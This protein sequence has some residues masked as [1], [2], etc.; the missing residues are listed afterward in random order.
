[1]ALGSKALI[2][3]CLTAAAYA[4]EYPARHDHWRRSCT[5]TLKVDD[6]GVSFTS[7]K[8]SFA[9]K[10]EDIQQLDISPKHLRVRTYKDN[11][12]KAGIDETNEFLGSFESA[13][14]LLKGRVL[15]R[16]PDPSVD[17]TWTV[18]VKLMARIRGSEGDLLIGTKQIV[19]RTK[20][21][22]NS[23]T[24]EFD[25]IENIST[26]HRYELTLTTLDRDYCFQ[27]K[28]P[29][30][31]D[32]YDALWLRLQQHKGLKLIGESK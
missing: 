19:Y 4:A 31:Q 30:A 15:N 28:Q 3:L 1:M 7:P 21:P 8:H 5:G 14:P 20:S 17:T 6:A 22:E 2:A 10:Y 32:R 23:R 11:L 9:W 18:P 26:S 24:W 29:L 13:E 12:W 25:D 27:L 16:I